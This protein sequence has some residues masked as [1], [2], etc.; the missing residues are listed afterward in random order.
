MSNTSL[1]PIHGGSDQSGSGSQ[2][3]SGENQNTHQAALPPATNP[4]QASQIENGRQAGRRVLGEIPVPTDPAHKQHNQLFLQKPKSF[5][6]AGS[7]GEDPFGGSANLAAHSGRCHPCP[8]YEGQ[9]HHECHEKCAAKLYIKTHERLVDQRFFRGSLWESR[10]GTYMRQ[11]DVANM[12]EF[13]ERF[14]WTTTQ[15]DKRRFFLSNGAGL[16]VER[17]PQGLLE[18]KIVRGPLDRHK[19]NHDSLARSGIRPEQLLEDLV[20]EQVWKVEADGEEIAYSSIDDLLSPKWSTDTQFKIFYIDQRLSHLPEDVTVRLERFR[21]SPWE[22][23]V[24]VPADV[25]ARQPHIRDYDTTELDD[26]AKKA[27]QK[28]VGDFQANLQANKEANDKR[29]KKPDNAQNQAQDAVG[30]E[31]ERNADAAKSATEGNVAAQVADAPVA[32]VTKPASPT[33]APLQTPTVTEPTSDVNQQPDQGANAAKG[34]TASDPQSVSSSSLLSAARSIS[35]PPAMKPLEI[36]KEDSSND[37]AVPTGVTTR[38]MARKAK[39]V[40]GRKA[41]AGNAKAGNVK[42]ATTKKVDG[43][44]KNKVTKSTRPQQGQ[45]RQNRPGSDGDTGGESDDQKPQPKK[46]TRGRGRPAKK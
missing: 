23:L 30:S 12:D 7:G 43:K 45:G 32:P 18:Y 14:Q 21:T 31:D 36:K 17:R 26:A 34:T 15:L 1:P 35:A 20:P 13:V 33:Q 16:T 3:S 28:N 22:K 46:P 19:A 41:Q 40:K 2:S 6:A 11:E 9:Y 10:W 42:K 4:Y 39:G 37:A 44:T 24:I 29:A 25:P 8:F 5:T 27:G 38:A